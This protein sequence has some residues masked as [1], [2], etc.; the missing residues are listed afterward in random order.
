M[1]KDVIRS[2]FLA[3][4]V[5]LIL[6]IPRPTNSFS[7]SNIPYAY[8]WDMDK[9]RNYTVG[10]AY[11]LGFNATYKLDM[12]SSSVTTRP[13]SVRTSYYILPVKDLTFS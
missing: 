13:F 9:K 4:E 3:F 5:D 7:T 11:T 2:S 12:S 8:M 6:S 10:F 1:E